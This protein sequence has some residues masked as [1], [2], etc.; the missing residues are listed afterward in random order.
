M[1]VWLRACLPDFN[2]YQSILFGSGHNWNEVMVECLDVGWVIGRTFSTWTSMSTDTPFSA[3]EIKLTSDVNIFCLK[4]IFILYWEIVEKQTFSYI[5]CRCFHRKK[6]AKKFGQLHCFVFV[7]FYRL[8][9]ELAVGN[10]ESS[11]AQKLKIHFCLFAFSFL[12]LI[13]II[14]WEISKIFVL[15]IRYFY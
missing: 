7:F 11:S 10:T 9:S 2:P 6:A 3:A 4:K 14:K 1:Q 8:R 5:F 12:F 15:L 13:K